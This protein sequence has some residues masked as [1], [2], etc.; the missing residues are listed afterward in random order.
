ME[1]VVLIAVGIV[2][3][4]LGS[5]IG[6]GGGII[7]VPTLVNLSLYLPQ[8]THVTPQIAAGTSMVVTIVTAVSSTMTYHKHKTI[9]YKSGLILCIGSVPAGMLGSYVNKFFDITSFQL[10]FGAFL[11]FMAFLLYMKK[12]IRN[13]EFKGTTGF[14]RTFT[15]N[16]GKTYRYGFHPIVAILVSFIAGFLSGLFGI[17]GGSLLGPAMI[18]LFYFPP[19]ISVATSMFV[20]MITSTIS[21]TT[22]V[23]L[24]NVNWL[25][26]LFLA[27]G[28]FIGSKL[29]SKLNTKLKGDTILHILKITVFILGVKMILEGL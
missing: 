19:H 5:L 10:Y 7:I 17:G 15:D 14:I 25:Y 24:G 3:G 9:D 22:H 13:R 16:S 8:F 11:I 2:A 27:P 26:V 18:M 23:A 28:A 1:Y 21:A 20:I 4:G 29:G 6:L 12:Y